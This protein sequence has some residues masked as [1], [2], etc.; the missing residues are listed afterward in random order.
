MTSRDRLASHLITRQAWTHCR[1]WQMEF[2]APRCC[3][4]RDS[5]LRSCGTASGALWLA[6]TLVTD[7][8][9]RLSPIYCMRRSKRHLVPEAPG[10]FTPPRLCRLLVVLLTSLFST[11]GT[12]LPTT[13]KFFSKASSS[14]AGASI[15][16][17]V[18]C[19]CVYTDVCMY[20]CTCVLTKTRLVSP[21]IWADPT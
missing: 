5:V 4:A 1:L 2:C 17:R 9:L 15:Q 19:S 11:Q 3:P 21:R 7:F 16:P 8:W 18:V 14:K 12:E 6:V 10:G 13:L 20:I